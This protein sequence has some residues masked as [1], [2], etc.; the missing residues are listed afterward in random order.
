MLM[1]T[2]PTLDLNSQHPITPRQR[3][4]ATTSTFAYANSSR[5]L[6]GPQ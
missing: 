5:V 1:L 3:L 6:D 4:T 2:A